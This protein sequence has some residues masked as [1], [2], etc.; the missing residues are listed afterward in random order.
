MRQINLIFYAEEPGPGALIERG[1]WRIERAQ[2]SLR[3]FP[4]VDQKR[5]E[6][7][8]SR[9]KVDL[10]AQQV[11]QP[12]AA[13]ALLVFW[14]VGYHHG[15]V[16]AVNAFRKPGATLNDWAEQT[17]A[18]SPGAE[19]HASLGV[20]TRNKVGSGIAQFIVAHLGANS[21]RT[22]RSLSELR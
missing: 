22:C 9:R 6:Q 17:K 5:A 13:G 11:A 15:A 14:Q 8:V 19:V 18:R 10:R 7:N 12:Q 4:G 3:R 21:E 20:Q 1:R 16:F 2:A